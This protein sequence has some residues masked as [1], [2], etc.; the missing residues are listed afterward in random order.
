[1]TKT[2]HKVMNLDGPAEY[3]ETYKSD[4]SAVY[5]VYRADID[6]SEAVPIVMDGQDQETIEAVQDNCQ[7]IT[8]I[9]RDV[10]QSAL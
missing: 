4:E 9:C 2:C 3:W 8:S 6:G 7:F 1:M 5:D 10:K